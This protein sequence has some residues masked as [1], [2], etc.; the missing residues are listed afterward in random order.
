MR[1]FCGRGLLAAPV[2]YEV[3]VL[4]FVGGLRM[5]AAYF[6]RY[7]GPEILS[8]GDRPLPRPGPG[9]VRVRVA[10]AGVNPVDWKM[11]S[12]HFRWLIPVRFPAI[13]GFDVAGVVDAVGKRVTTLRE[14]DRVH[15]RMTT[16]GACAEYAIIKAD[17]VAPV[18]PEMPMAEAAA[19]P[20]AGMTALQAL[21]DR[22][23]MPLANASQRVL[24]VGASGGVGHLAVQIAKTMGAEVVGV[25]SARNVEF[26]TGLGADSVLDYNLPD[27]YREQRPFDCVLDCVSDNPDAFMPL[28]TR[29]GIYAAVLPGPKVM[30]RSLLNILGGRRARPVMLR[31]SGLDLRLLDDW[32]Q[33]GLLRVTLD[34]RYPLDDVAAA[35]QRSMSGRTVGKIVVEVGPS[36][37]LRE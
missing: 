4:G 34:A 12:G 27:V 5:R 17:V 11:A 37:S 26:V 13:P 22:C 29:R 33:R 2:G 35:W 25:C 15:A 3:S 16:L 9:E 7:G 32:W 28:L 6:T 8:V 1:G 10:A 19:L 18:P 30:A 14:G 23:E 24:V 36:G 21:R 31:R 20:L